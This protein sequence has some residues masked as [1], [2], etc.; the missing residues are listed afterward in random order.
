[1]RAAAL[2]G[3][4]S[5]AACAPPTPPRARDELLFELPHWCGQ[6][7]R[8]GWTAWEGA[9]RAAPDGAAVCGVRLPTGDGDGVCVVLREGR[10][11]SARVVASG[12]E[13]VAREL[14]GLEVSRGWA[15]VP[16]VPETFVRVD[17]ETLAVRAPAGAREGPCFHGRVAAAFVAPGARVL[18][19]P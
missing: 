10:V 5:I 16:S 15:L 17:G 14:V 8:Q 2:V 19:A 18:I 9:R 1:M 13:R 4:I 7:R 6:G 11:V 3:A 12:E